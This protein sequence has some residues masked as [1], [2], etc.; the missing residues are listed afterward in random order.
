MTI[1]RPAL[2]LLSAIAFALPSTLSWAATAAAG[3]ATGRAPLAPL[4]GEVIV[5]FK[6]GAATLRKH[7]LAARADA[8]TVRS[9]LA[10]RAATLGARLGRALHT[11]AAVGEHV[12][13]VRAEGL[14][15][16]SL[17]RLLAADP[18]VAYAVPNGRKRIVNAPNDPLYLAGP[19]INLARQ[20]GGPASGQWYL[21]APDSSIKSAIDIEAAWLLTTGSSNVVV[22]VLDTGVRFEHPD[23]SR[24]LLPGFDFVSDAEVANDGRAQGIQ[25]TR[26]GAL[27]AVNWDDDPSDPGDWV[28]AAEASSSKF[29][30]CGISDSS[31]HGTSTASLIAAAT[32]TTP[33]AGMS[34]TAPGVRLLPVRVLGKCFGSDA[35][36]IAAMRWAAGIPVDGV[37]ANPHPA[38]VINM[39][40][41]GDGA[42]TAAYQTV[43]DELT[44][45]GV[46]VV[47]AAGNSAGG[48]VSEPA[49]CRDVIGVLA[50]RHAGTKVGFSDLGS[51]IGIAAPG[52]NCIN[53]TEGSACLYPIVVAT[54]SGNTGPLA[55]SWT[56]SFDFSVGTSFSSPLVAGVV[57][58][59]LSR[60]PALTAAQV[61]LALQG[62]ARPFPTS[63][64]D[65]GTDTLSVR[66]C[67]EP[68]RFSGTSRDL[69]CYCVTGLC[70]AGMLDAGAAVA[71][72][73]SGPFVSVS[74]DPLVPVQGETI[75]LRIT[76]MQ[77]Q[78][79]RPVRGY[80]WEIVDSGGV[81]NGF[82]G[83]S[84]AETASVTASGPGLFKVR[85]TVTDSQG[86][87][88]TLLQ[89]TPVLAA[90]PSEQP[91]DTVGGG[92]G[93][94]GGGGGSTSAAWVAGVGLAAA[95]LQLLRMHA[96]R[97]ARRR[98]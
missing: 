67:N 77:T 23:L 10:D 18:E 9:A 63:G 82:V 15:A 86:S 85:L 60:Q 27:S 92:G 97:A 1:A 8:A 38:K 41:G 75:K 74:T 5:G 42:C 43:I 17:A 19:A 90:V 2:L 68:N 28:T 79:S 3:T 55:S 34:G 11:G 52:G 49:N 13:V 6:P 30:D 22:A 70:G 93:G 20:T 53:I 35:D 57:A 84:N 64:A 69:Q 26:N 14:D 65:N 89:S 40:L 96:V 56:D 37:P 29:K 33:A 39:S 76:G 83:A 21:R 54:N 45:R 73:G 98:V 72:A 58:L 51:E 36:I 44:A 66:R 25:T 87:T 32:N 4:D 59:M 47:A 94:D 7:A 24:R 78:D 95:V 71:A 48:A 91:A 80:A 46:T 12:Q 61:R 81:V 50:L 88:I 31:W 62:S 16:A